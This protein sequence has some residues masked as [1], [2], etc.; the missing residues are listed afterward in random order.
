M[1][2]DDFP[3]LADLLAARTLAKAWWI[4]YPQAPQCHHASVLPTRAQRNR[5]S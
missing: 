4:G 3:N 1:L 2:N 5:R